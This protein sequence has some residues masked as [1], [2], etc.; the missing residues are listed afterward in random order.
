MDKNRA[1]F[2]R[3]KEG[4]EV[5]RTASAD[6]KPALSFG[7]A[8]QWNSAVQGQLGVAFA[9]PTKTVVY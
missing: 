6:L 2:T 4:P 7:E 9:I 3:F 1:I 8:E 5:S